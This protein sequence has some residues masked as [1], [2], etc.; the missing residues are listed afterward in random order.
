MHG[1]AHVEIDSQSYG[2]PP[3]H[4]SRFDYG[5]FADHD[6]DN[7]LTPPRNSHGREDACDSELML[8]VL[9]F[10]GFVNK[11]PALQSRAHG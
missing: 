11:M 6:F 9:H 7:V 5:N 4:G 1:L 10:L 3:K 8:S 2:F